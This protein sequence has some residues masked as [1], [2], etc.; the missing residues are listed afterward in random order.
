M[1]HQIVIGSIVILTALYIYFLKRTNTPEVKDKIYVRM[2]KKYSEIG[3]FFLG[4][5]VFIEG[6]ALFKRVPSEEIHFAFGGIILTLFGLGYY[7]L[8]TYKHFKIEMRK[9]EFEVYNVFKKNAIYKYTDV[10]AVKFN[11]ISYLYTI[12]MHDNT[13][14]KISVYTSSELQHLFN[15]INE[16]GYNH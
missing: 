5:G 1:F 7:I 9:Y 8:L 10:K 14:I 2:S 6:M 11:S 13:R 12:K 15:I 16:G 3:L 4:I